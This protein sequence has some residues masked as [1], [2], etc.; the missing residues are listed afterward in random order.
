MNEES[1]SN[2]FQKSATQQEQVASAI[3]EF[4]AVAASVYYDKHEIEK[5]RKV[6]AA[7]DSPRALN[8]YNIYDTH[9]KEFLA[10][11][12][13][14]AAKV[15][16]KLRPRIL[17]IEDLWDKVLKHPLDKAGETAW[18]DELDAIRQEVFDS[19]AY[20]PRLEWQWRR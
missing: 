11:S 2:L 13:K 6:G 12:T 7:D 10:A 19:I 1:R 8:L 16:P 18:F 14:L 15:P 3:A 4:N 5:A 17:A 9:Y 20:H